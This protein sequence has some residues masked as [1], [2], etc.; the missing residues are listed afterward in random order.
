MKNP[1][2]AALD[3]D[4]VSRAEKLAR[5][6]GPFVGGFKVGPRLVLRAGKNFLADLSQSGIV[7]FDPKFFDI[8]STTVASVEAAAEWG[9][10]WVTVHTLNGPA[11]LKELAQLEARVRQSKPAFRI[12][13]V[14]VLTSFS[15]ETLPPIWKKQDIEE[16]VEELALSA[17]QQGIKSFVCSPQEVGKMKKK[18][19]DGFWVVPGVRPEGFPSHDQIRTATPA[20]ALQ[21]GASALVLG[22]PF[23]E[24][25]DPA[26]VAQEI[27]ESLE[28]GG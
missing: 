23:I 25:K 26:G 27:L 11:C 28:A 12:L 8:P 2:I 20:Q 6:L 14:T 16:S 1:L 24:S 5:I 19:S 18:F 13:G 4:D 3:V 7:F 9:A 17:Y 15:K 21:A 10:D 22:R